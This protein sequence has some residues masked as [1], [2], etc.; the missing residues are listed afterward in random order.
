MRVTE[1]FQVDAFTIYE[2]PMP[3]GKSVLDPI[4]VLLRDFGGS[5]QVIVECY[6][7][8]WSCWFGA[9]GSY[10]L[11]LFLAGCDEHYLAGKLG[12]VTHRSTTKREE[13]Y[14]RHI[15][16]AVIAALKGDAA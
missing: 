9:I 16:R 4:T 15:A 1:Q 7:A 10:T 11:R 13:A 2:A 8:A 14:L 6:G 5:G 12:C 3:P